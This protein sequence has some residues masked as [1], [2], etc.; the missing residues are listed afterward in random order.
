M[1]FHAIECG[2]TTRP[3]CGE[4]PGQVVTGNLPL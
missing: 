3:G 1:T 4:S 2:V